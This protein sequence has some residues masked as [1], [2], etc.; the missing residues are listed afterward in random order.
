[1]CVCVGGGGGR[2]GGRG[3]AWRCEGSLELFEFHVLSINFFQVVKC[4]QVLP[5]YVQR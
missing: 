4:W 5:Q 2:N 3:G 1:M